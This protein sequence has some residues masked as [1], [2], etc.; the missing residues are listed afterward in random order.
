MK[1]L[2]AKFTQ[3][4]DLKRVLLETKDA[5]LVEFKRRDVPSVDTALM[6]IRKQ[7]NAEIA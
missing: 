3:N 6:Q 5:K 2:E 4:L 1:G 7:L